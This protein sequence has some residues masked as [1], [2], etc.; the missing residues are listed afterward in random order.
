MTECVKGQGLT[1]EEPE[2]GRYAQRRSISLVRQLRNPTD[3]GLFQSYSSLF[4]AIQGYSRLFKAKNYFIAQITR[5]RRATHVAFL[6]GTQSGSI[7]H[8]RSGAAAR[9]SIRDQ[10]GTTGEKTAHPPRFAGAHFSSFSG[11]VGAPYG[12][13]APSLTLT[14]LLTPVLPNRFEKNNKK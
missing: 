4:K 2:P 6:I 7:P 8:T 1:T 11:T 14:L 5:R 3:F 13:G 9:Y 10:G 12:P